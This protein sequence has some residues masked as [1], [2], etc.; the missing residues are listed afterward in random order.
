LLTHRTGH[1]LDVLFQA[2][3]RD[4]SAVPF[5]KRTVLNAGIATTTTG[6]TVRPTRAPRERAGKTLPFPDAKT[7]EGDAMGVVG[8]L[9][10][11]P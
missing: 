5:G 6:H 4:G 8:W 11:R 10:V 1:A 3:M 2:Q 9:H 7:A